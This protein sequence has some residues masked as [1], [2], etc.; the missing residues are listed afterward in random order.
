MAIV[1]KTQS[2]HHRNEDYRKAQ[3]I[4]N[5]PVNPTTFEKFSMTFTIVPQIWL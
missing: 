3:Y 2:T 4:C 5:S 1:Y